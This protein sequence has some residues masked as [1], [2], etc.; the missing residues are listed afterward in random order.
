MIKPKISEETKKKQGRGE[1]T[2]A[3]YKPWIYTNEFNSLGTVSNPVDFITG[4]V[5]QLMSMGEN[6]FYYL[7][8]WDDN[9]LDIR[10]QF[11]LNLKDTL[12]ISEDLHVRHP[13][14]KS[15]RMTSDFLVDYADGSQKVFSVKY[16]KNDMS[17]SFVF[18][19]HLL[20][21]KLYCYPINCQKT[22]AKVIGFSPILE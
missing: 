21:N 11:P 8:C 15:T 1:G 16:S 5:M 22:R 3:D 13:K 6:K 10:E 12:K 20:P 14:N 9:V 2:G 7:L 18:L 17:N 4:R 19:Y